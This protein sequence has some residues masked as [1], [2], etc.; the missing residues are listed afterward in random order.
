MQLNDK[1]IQLVATSDSTGLVI[2]LFA[3]TEAGRV[4][5]R[6]EFTERGEWHEILPNADTDIDD[7]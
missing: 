6:R 3:L 1:I 5:H 4:Y 7:E 2:R